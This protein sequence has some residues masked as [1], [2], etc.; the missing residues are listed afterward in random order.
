[1]LDSNPLIF[2]SIVIPYNTDLED[3]ELL[4]WALQ[5]IVD[6]AAAVASLVDDEFGTADTTLVVPRWVSDTCVEHDGLMLVFVCHCSR[7]ALPV[8]CGE[9]TKSWLGRTRRKSVCPSVLVHFLYPS[10]ACV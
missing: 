10:Y 6:L 9:R 2:S 8:C 1:M 7:N 4:L 5:C 3:A